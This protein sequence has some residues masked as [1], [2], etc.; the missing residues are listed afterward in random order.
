MTA[1]SQY[2]ETEIKKSGL[3]KSYLASK[4]GI[5]R[6]S[7]STKCKEPSQFTCAQV[8]VLCEELKI[9]QLTQRDRIFFT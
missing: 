3:K 4:L 2:L 1:N 5:T 9:T 7:F 6:Q 8:A